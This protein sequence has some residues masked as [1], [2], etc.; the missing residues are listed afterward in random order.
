MKFS[1]KNEDGTAALESF[2]TLPV[3]IGQ[4]LTK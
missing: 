2:G 4:V 1:G 3:F